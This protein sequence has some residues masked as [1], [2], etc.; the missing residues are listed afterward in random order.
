M[1]LPGKIRR[2]IF[3]IFLV[4]FILLSAISLQAQNKIYLTMEESISRALTKNN[5]VRASEFAIKKANWDKKNAWTL[6][7]PT[8][9]L[10]TRFTWIDDSTFALRDFSRY[11]RDMP[12]IP[13]IP[14]FEIPQTVFQESYFTAFDVSMPLFNGSLLN[15]LFTANASKEMAI[16]L[17]ESTRDNI[18]FQVIS[19]Y[20]NVLRNQEILKL[21]KEY[22]QLSQLNYEKAER[23]YN[24]GRYSKTEALR[25]KVDFQQQKSVVVTSESTLRSS[26]TILTRLINMDIDENVDFQAKIP[27]QLIDE[28]ERIATLSDNEILE[29]IRLNENEL[30]QANAALSAAKS[31]EEISKSLYRNSYA[32]YLPNLSFNYSYAWR[33]NSTFDL[34]DY[35]PQTFMINLSVPIFT[36]FQNFTA[37]KSTYYDFKKSQ[38]EF[39]DQLQN[40]RFILTETANKLINLKTQRELSMANVEYNNHNYRTVE[41]QK[42]KG[43]IS[44]IDFID[45]KLN[46]QDAR[47]NDI[48]THYDFISAML[49]LYFLLGKLEYVIKP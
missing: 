1:I 9:S 40:T 22:L 44:N 32:S 5:Q 45:A 19:G 42:E 46:L 14:S 2:T 13:G 10:S 17:H 31:N 8:V 20:L 16:Q 34:D 35:S 38:E 43:L 47:L 4:A 28:S 30:I 7:F 36:S 21:Q 6:L 37:S 33:E 26:M 18:I 12:E 24:A 48:S 23:L 49:E 3:F 11:F 15:N 41:Q 29:M 25:W 27:Q 39:L